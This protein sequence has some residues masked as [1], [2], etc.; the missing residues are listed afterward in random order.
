MD[1]TKSISSYLTRLL[2]PS[3]SGGSGMK[4]LLLDSHTTP[5]IS[6]SLTQ[7]A[8]LS[9]EV[10][11]TD[12]VDN[13]ARERM[14][15]LKCIVLLRPTEASIEALCKELKWPKY[16]GYWLYFTNVLKK[17]DIER[18]AEADEHDAV[19][20]VQEYFADYLPVNSSLFSLSPTPLPTGNITGPIGPWAS[21]ASEWDPA[22]LDRHTQGLM[23]LLL[24]LK[25]K[26]VVRYE[27]MSA[28]AKKLGEEISYQTTQGQP[29]LFDFRRSE[30]A[31]LL[32][33]LDRRNDPVTPLLSQWTYQA[34]IHELLGIN[35]GRVSLPASSGLKP[36]QR[37]LV[38]SSSEDP[39]FQQNLYDNFGDLGASIKRYVLEFQTKTASSKQ[40]ETV[41]DMKRFVEE[42]P[43]FRKL[44]GN[45]SKHVTLLGE[46]SRRVEG[47]HLLEVSELEQS[48]ASNES[49]ASDLKAVYDLLA[50]PDILSEAKLRVAILYALRYQR[51]SGNQISNVVK[52]L[53]ESGVEESRAGLVFVMLNFAGADQRQDDLFSND[54]FFSRG[55]SALKGL[56][57]VDNVYTQH[58]PHLLETVEL[59]MKGRL[60]E[61]SYPST[62]S[63]SAGGSGP[64]GASGPGGGGGYSTSSSGLITQRPR[65]IILFIIGGATY[66]EARAISL[67]N[68]QGANG[69]GMGARFLLGG[70]TIHNSQS[71]LTMVQDA[72]SRFPASIARPPPTSTGLGAAGASGSSAGSGQG[73]GLNL[74]IGPVQLNVGRDGRGGGGGGGDGFTGAGGLVDPG[75]IGEAAQGAANLAGG[76]LGR[77]RDAI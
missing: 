22:A 50:R 24:S 1:V 55:K 29:S 39:F 3:A 20:E 12:R 11:L 42:Y 77:L 15:H 62:S 14:K 65:D 54:N 64:G 63:S 74:R 17:G 59:L 72:A 23:A 56:K 45:V 25:K 2:S 8:L 21:N 47:E 48:L 37:E 31:P 28:L 69:P 73:Q 70:S 67:L 38:L 40:I 68:S 66:E 10:Y 35:N 27:R 53:L 57:G 7:S 41:Q 5:V 52:Q 58:T 4:V 61:S 60:R 13:E 18:L 32:L 36:E 26:P 44:S 71:F 34:M 33:I 16:G 46:L 9:H 43:E 51:Y 19:K 76:L 6:S 75:R 30:P 49:H